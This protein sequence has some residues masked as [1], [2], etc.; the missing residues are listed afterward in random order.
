[1][2]D[3]FGIQSDGKE[4]TQPDKF[5][6]GNY[7]ITGIDRFIDE[8]DRGLPVM[9]PSKLDNSMQVRVAYKTADGEGPPQSLSLPDML[10]VAKAF[11]VDIREFA[12]APPADGKETAWLLEVLDA[13]NKSGNT[14]SGWVNDSG[15]VSSIKNAELP[16]GRYAFKLV[17]VNR[18]NGEISWSTTRN[19]GLRTYV[20]FECVGSEFGEPCYYNGV[21]MGAP[22]YDPVDHVDADKN[23]VVFKV[24]DKGYKTIYEEIF[25]SLVRCLAPTASDG[26]EWSAVKLG[27]V[28][29]VVSYSIEAMLAHDKMVTLD[30][31]YLK[32][33]ST[34]RS[35]NMRTIEPFDLKDQPVDL[36]DEQE[37]AEQQDYQMFSLVTFLDQLGEGLDV[38][39]MFEDTDKD[40]SQINLALTKAG[41]EWCREN[42]IETWDNLELPSSHQFADLSPEQAEQLEK[43]LRLKFESTI[44]DTGF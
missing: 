17:G 8:D 13:I 15:W 31:G 7:D 21:R 43:A 11:G 14:V 30:V 41:K 12:P 6:S 38:G 40:S 44:D 35:L 3:I 5:K 28:D 37:E 26:R 9:Q 10:M 18:R 22:I 16:S 2:T 20:Y 27:G 23:V 39:P 29:N 24:T 33:N 25:L 36:D 42:L 4:F 1:M 32:A 19:G 34:F